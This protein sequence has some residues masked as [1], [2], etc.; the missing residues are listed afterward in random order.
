MAYKLKGLIPRTLA[1]D[2][3]FL[4]WRFH[5]PLSMLCP[6]TSF[7]RLRIMQLYP[8]GLPQNY[9]ESRLSSQ[10]MKFGEIYGGSCLT[11]AELDLYYTIFTSVLFYLSNIIMWLLIPTL[12]SVILSIIL[13]Q[14]IYREYIWV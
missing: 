5:M 12:Q 10:Y 14:K 6:V 13:R 2:I 11:W 4:Y 3:G 7:I 1:E 8:P 9:Q